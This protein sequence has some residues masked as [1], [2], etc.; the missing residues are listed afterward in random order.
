M[1]LCGVPAGYAGAPG[2]T[3]GGTAGGREV[4]KEASPAAS[5]FALSLYMVR[6]SFSSSSSSPASPNRTLLP[7]CFLLDD[8]SE[9]GDKSTLSKKF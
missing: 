1:S 3:R 4:L 9:T 6:V 2:G 5:R 7:D 8:G